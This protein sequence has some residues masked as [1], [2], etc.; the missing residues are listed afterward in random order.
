MYWK[1]FRIQLLT[2]TFGANLFVLGILILFPNLG[3]PKNKPLVFPEEV[4]LSQWRMI[5]SQDVK[6][7]KEKYPELLSQRNY[8]YLK[9][10]INLNIEMRYLQNFYPADVTIPKNHSS[11]TKA[12]NTVRYQEG[13]GYYGVGIYEQNAYLRSCINPRGGSTF[14]HAQYRQNRYSQDISFARLL[15]VL[16]GQEAL[17]D[18]RCLLVYLSMP[19]KNSSPENAYQILEQAWVSWYQWWQPQFPKP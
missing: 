4:P 2:L 17:L 7:N 9:D 13:I 8:Q 18:K 12:S 11:A 14:T 6:I 10:D 16:Q 1:K 15:P 5:S 19:L 3:Q